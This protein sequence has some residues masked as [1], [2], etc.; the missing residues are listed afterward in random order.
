MKTRNV[1]PILAVALACLFPASAAPAASAPGSSPPAH[2]EGRIP[3]EGISG[4]RLV[5]AGALFVMVGLLLWALLGGQESSPPTREATAVPT[6]A[7]GRAPTAL[8]EV[9]A[10]PGSGIC[11]L[12]RGEGALRGLDRL[13]RRPRLPVLRQ[14]RRRRRPDRRP[15]LRRRGL[16]P[17]PATGSGAR[18]LRG[19]EPAGLCDAL[20]APS[21]LVR[22]AG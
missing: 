7:A 17:Q 21:D 3:L 22:K 6:G 11:W 10:A 2:E 5:G 13:R 14:A 4:R 16:S 12:R 20:L 15:A 8:P 18:E 1:C 9:D 19:K